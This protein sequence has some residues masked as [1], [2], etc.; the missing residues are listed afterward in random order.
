MV[1][2][3]L[4]QSKGGYPGP[5]R[6]YLKVNLDLQWAPTITSDSEVQLK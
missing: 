5:A 6:P 2:H 3:N 4:T 1:H